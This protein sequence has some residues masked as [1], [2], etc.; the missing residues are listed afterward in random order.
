VL[1]PT[2]PSHQPEKL[3]I[4]YVH[5]CV[6]MRVHFVCVCVCACTCACASAGV[7]VCMR[8]CDCVRVHVCV[9][10]CVCVCVVCV[11]MH[12]RVYK[13]THAHVCAQQ[14]PGRKKKC[15]IGQQS[16]PDWWPEQGR[17]EMATLILWPPLSWSPSR[18]FFTSKS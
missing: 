8:V 17:A 10:V 4:S 11:C 16:T 18:T 5:V 7:F 3:V 9:S 1:L 14:L 13:H 6:R 12:V 15:L 2:E